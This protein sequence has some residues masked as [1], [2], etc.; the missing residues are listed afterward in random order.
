VLHN[1]KE[2][3]NVPIYVIFWGPQHSSVKIDKI[4]K[5]GEIEDSNV[6]EWNDFVKT[7]LSMIEKI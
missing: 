3:L 7:L 5:I 4:I 1:L 2:H 6:V